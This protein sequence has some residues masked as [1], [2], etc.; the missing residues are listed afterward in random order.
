MLLLYTT[1]FKIRL[2]FYYKYPTQYEII[3]SYVVETKSKDHR[4]TCNHANDIAK[5]CVFSAYDVNVTLESE[6]ST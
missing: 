1:K 4:D 6:K 5:E 3:N 2:R